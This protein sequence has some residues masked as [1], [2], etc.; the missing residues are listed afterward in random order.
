VS[1]PFG[2]IG[3]DDRMREDWLVTCST[4][5]HGAF[6]M[7][8]RLRH[9]RP[10]RVGAGGLMD[11]ISYLPRE[12]SLVFLIS[13]FHMPLDVLGEAVNGLTRHQLVPIVLWDDA[14]YRNL[15]DF[16]IASVTD[17]ETGAR[18]T[19]FLRQG[20]RQR[21]EQAFA[22][23][24]RMLHQFFLSYDAPPF[25]IEDGFDPDALTEYF[26]QFISP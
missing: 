3:F 2:F 21:I 19:L 8:E 10:A 22:E 15:P 16:G 23:R 5:A 26:Y 18:R 13:D 14:E 7:A 11:A 1:D 24:R 4:R 6:D 12:R 20:F 17:C 9:Y 25:F